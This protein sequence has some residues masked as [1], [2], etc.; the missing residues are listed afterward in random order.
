MTKPSLT[1]CF[2]SFQQLSSHIFSGIRKTPF[3]KTPTWKTPTHQI[4]PWWISPRK[5][6]KTFWCFFLWILKIFWVTSWLQREISNVTLSKQ[7][8][9]IKKQRQVPKKVPLLFNLLQ[10]PQVK[11]RSS[12]FD[13]KSRSKLLNRLNTTIIFHQ[14]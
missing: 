6:R 4:P 3:R 11:R 13:R 10:T 9:L 1:S 14:K 7:I 5:I 8:T 2:L 12:M